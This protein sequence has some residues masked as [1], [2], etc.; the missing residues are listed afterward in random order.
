MGEEFILPPVLNLDNVYEASSP[1]SP[2]VF[3]LSPGADPCKDLT[4]LAKRCDVDE[5]DFQRI[6]LG[7]GQEKVRHR[8][9]S[10][11]YFLK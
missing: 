7:L 3:I 9:F 8:N 10:L 6:S 1:E 11:A 5:A 4:K 2:V